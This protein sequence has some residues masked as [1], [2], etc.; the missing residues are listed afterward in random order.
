MEAPKEQEHT[1]DG[2]AALTADLVVRARR[3]DAEAFAQ[4]ISRYERVALSVAFAV[5]GNGDA[6]GDVVQESFLRAWQRLDELKDPRCFGTWL[7]G[8]ARNL[9][10]DAKRRSKHVKLSFDACS[11]EPPVIADERLAPDP[12]DEL[13]RREQH[14]RVA[15]A[16]QELDE[17]TRSAVILRYY[18]DLS[19]KEIAELL[20]ISPAAVDMRLSRGRQALKMILNPVT[21]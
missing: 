1:G 2:A 19:S 16:L 4:L 8:I 20:Q 5:L 14:A 6:A 18:D 12:V 9:G 17:L 15:D 13:S 3:K 10:I 21:T 7:C 11:T